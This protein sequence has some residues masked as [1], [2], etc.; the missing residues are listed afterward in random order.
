VSS[1]D[2]RRRTP[3]EETRPLVARAPMAGQ[4]GSQPLGSFVT[5][6]SVSPLK[7]VSKEPGVVG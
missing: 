3:L 1:F 2:S 6:A 4:R 7:E 5:K